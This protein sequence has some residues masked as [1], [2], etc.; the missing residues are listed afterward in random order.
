[1]GYIVSL[2]ISHEFIPI[3]SLDVEVGVMVGLPPVHYSLEQL[4]CCENNL[5]TVGTLTYLQ[6]PLDRLQP[7]LC[8]QGI[9]GLRIG[10]RVGPKKFSPQPTLGRWWWWCMLLLGLLVR[11]QMPK[12]LQ[13]CLHE[14]ILVGDELLD[15]RVGLIVGVAALVVAVVPRVHH[16]RGF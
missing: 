6:L 3:H 14:Q 1:V 5:P 11:L 12:G 8:I 15:L 10:V 7:V 4:V 9:L 2:E 13:H 16:L